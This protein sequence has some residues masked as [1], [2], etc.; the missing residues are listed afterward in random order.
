[1]GPVTVDVTCTKH[2]IKAMPL[3]TSLFLQVSEYF[4]V[5]AVIFYVCNAS[6]EVIRLPENAQKFTFHKL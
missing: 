4:K 6:R 1:M 2:S 5:E 3:C